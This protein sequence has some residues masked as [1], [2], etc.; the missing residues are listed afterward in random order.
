MAYIYGQVSGPMVPYL[1][2]K[3]TFIVV[4]TLTLLMT[5]SCYLWNVS[6]IVVTSLQK[7]ILLIWIK[8]N[9]IMDK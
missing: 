2:N 8:L 6:L 3:D 5:S 1:F 4:S 7:A 9:P